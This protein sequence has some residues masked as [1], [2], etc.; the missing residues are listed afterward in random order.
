MALALKRRKWFVGA[1]AVVAASVL[2]IGGCDDGGAPGAGGN[3]ASPATRPAIAASHTQPASTDAT[4]TQF[5][6][7]FISIDGVATGFPP[8]RLRLTR[9]DE[10]VRALLFSDDPRN[11]TSADYK[12]NSFYFDVPLRLADPKDLNGAEYWYKAPDSDAEDDLPYGIFLGGIRGTH[13]QPQDL[14]VKFETDGEKVMV[15]LAGRFLV[16]QQDGKGP[17][18]QLAGASGTLYAT[19]ETKD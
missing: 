14:A 18:G 19:A 5:A 9:T 16:V 17:R 1:A 10:G 11:A 8:A 12:G 2:A 3:A 7:A 13:L 15:T 4:A 6:S